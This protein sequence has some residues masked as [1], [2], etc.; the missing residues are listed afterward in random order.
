[1]SRAPH[2]TTTKTTTTPAPPPPTLLGLSS[3]SLL[4]ATIATMVLFFWPV[5][6]KVGGQ[7]C[8]STF[9]RCGSGSSLFSQCVSGF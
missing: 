8:G 7:R 6:T 2:A 5:R 3:S 1:M 9:V 4:A